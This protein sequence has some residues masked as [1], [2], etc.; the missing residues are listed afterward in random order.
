MFVS[1]AN[2]VDR[3]DDAV[4]NV[5]ILLHHHERRPSVNFLLGV[6][7]VC[8]IDAI[9]D[10]LLEVVEGDEGGVY[11]GGVGGDL[12]EIAEGVEVGSADEIHAQDVADRETEREENAPDEVDPRKEGRAEGSFG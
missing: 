1:P 9:M 5:V 6:Q 10:V 7:E 3:S 12:V 4:E 11:V 2:L 8:P